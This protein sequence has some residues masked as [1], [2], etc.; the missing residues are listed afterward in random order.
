M[1][2]F[3]GVYETFF[4]G[5]LR[6]LERLGVDLQFLRFSILETGQNSPRD[7]MS[8][9]E[10][11]RVQR[12]LPVKW[13][14]SSW[15]FTPPRPPRQF[16]EAG[17]KNT[18]KHRVQPCERSVRKDL[19]IPRVKSANPKEVGLW[20]HHRE[21]GWWKSPPR[22]LMVSC[23]F[24]ARWFGIRNRAHPSNPI[25]FIF[26]DSRNANHR[27]PNQ[28]LA[29]SWPSLPLEKKTHVT[30]IIFFNP[31]SRLTARVFF[32]WT[33]RT[34]WMSRWKLGSMVGKWLI[35]YL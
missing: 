24:G 25:P 26:G 7:V 19:Y 16:F 32:C 23:W 29:I 11:F 8:G 1:L 35:T 6:N 30:W 13:E 9:N 15:W 3:R 22:Q 14:A 27:A 10:G 2:I 12:R 34:T 5:P 17:K 18:K 33:G 28:Q 21:R 4:P 20:N 31:W